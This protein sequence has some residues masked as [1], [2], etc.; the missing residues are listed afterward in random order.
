MEARG[1]SGTRIDLFDATDLLAERY[2]RLYVVDLE[3]IERN[4]PQLDYLQEVTRDTDAWVDAGVQS[5]DAVIDILVAGARRAV[6]STAH[7]ADPDQL[8]RAWRLTQALA[9]EVELGPD[10]RVNGP[11]PWP[12]DPRAVAAGARELGVGEV[13]LAP[14]GSPVDWGLVRE[15]GAAGPVWVGG[16]FAPSEAAR[17][18]EAGGVGGLFHLDAALL[19]EVERTNR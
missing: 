12:R 9:L 4:R 6:A 13:I 16:D 1:P 11:E 18:A 17:V 7:L 5:G 14:R 15:L 10:G 19:S 2:R 8:R 3:G